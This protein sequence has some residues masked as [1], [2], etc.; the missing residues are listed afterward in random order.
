[1][2]D[3]RHQILLDQ[4]QFDFV[5]F[6]QRRRRQQK[7]QLWLN[8]HRHFLDQWC[9]LHLH[10]CPHDRLRHPNHHYLLIQLDWL[11]RHRQLQ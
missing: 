4:Y 10:C 3:R 5:L 9:H 7:N 2:L 11:Q 6:H 8:Y 1:M